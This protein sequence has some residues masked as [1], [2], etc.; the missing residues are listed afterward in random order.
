MVVIKDIYLI[1]GIAHLSI[2]VATNVKRPVWMNMEAKSEAAGSGHSG[3]W[4]LPPIRLPVP[5]LHTHAKNLSF[6][7]IHPFNSPVSLD[8]ISFFCANRTSHGCT[9]FEII[10]VT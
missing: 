8:I 4:F 2:P 5:Q 6:S 7:L 3:P 1:T 10:G 9:S